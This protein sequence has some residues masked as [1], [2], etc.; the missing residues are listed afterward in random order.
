MV[1]PF[2]GSQWNPI[3]LSFSESGQLGFYAVYNPGDL[4]NAYG[5]VRVDSVIEG[6]A[7]P[8]CHINQISSTDA[9]FTG[10]LSLEKS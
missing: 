9:L 3:E 7:D 4:S 6:Q 10:A 2:L 1:P 5:Q 8:M